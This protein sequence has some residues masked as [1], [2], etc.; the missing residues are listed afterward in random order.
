MV[1][2]FYNINDQ[3]KRAEKLYSL[4]GNDILR[5]KKCAS[6]LEE[7]N[8]AIEDSRKLMKELGVVGSCSAC[9]GEKPGGCC[10]FGIESCYTDMLLLINMMLGVKIPGQRKL[11]KN[12]LFVGEQGCRLKARFKTCI[13][14]LCPQIK[15]SLKEYD[16]F[17][18]R[19]T[20]SHEINTG[21][22]TES[23]IRDMIRSNYNTSHE[24]SI[25]ED[26]TE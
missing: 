10:Y 6:L 12:C 15:D 9:A 16:L 8:T 24:S 2:F 1:H 25:P 4:Y 22:R 26:S 17:R 18:L 5:D 21:L 23:A 14:H 7:L 19:A 20:A 11:V 3:I 13:H